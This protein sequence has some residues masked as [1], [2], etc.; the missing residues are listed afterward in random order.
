[1]SVRAFTKPSASVL[2]CL[3]RSTQD[4]ACASTR[5]V[6]TPA[7]QATECGRLLPLWK[8]ALRKMWRR[9][10]S[11]GAPRRTLA[12][13]EADS[14]LRGRVRLTALLGYSGEDCAAP[15]LLSL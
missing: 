7:L 15:G 9:F 3:A 6:G 2:P 8:A 1:M 14:G 12:L 10:L 11:A 5:P 13:P 4:V